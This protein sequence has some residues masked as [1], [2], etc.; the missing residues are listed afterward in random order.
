MEILR[1]LVARLENF[2]G[3]PSDVPRLT[4]EYAS[5]GPGESRS[6]ILENSEHEARRRVVEEWWT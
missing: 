4:R 2:R 6:H 5:D 3:K 1:Y